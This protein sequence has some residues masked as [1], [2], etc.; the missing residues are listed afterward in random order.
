MALERAGQRVPALGAMAR[1]ER[2]PSTGGREGEGRWPCSGAGM[3][4]PQP[5]CGCSV[6]CRCPEQCPTPLVRSQRRDLC[7]GW[8][9]MPG[10]MPHSQVCPTSVPGA[11]PGTSCPMRPSCSAPCP[12]L[13][14][15]FSARFSAWCCALFPVQYRCPVQSQCLV[16]SPCNS[17]AVLGSRCNPSAFPV[18]S[19]CWAQFPV[20]SWFNPG[21]ISV[22]CPVPGS[23]QF[24]PG[25]ILV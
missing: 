25:V 12:G 11:V 13:C 2:G 3:A 9:P 22:L 15:G 18:P 17:G 23:V 4:G 1:G 24:N 21:A 16:Q 14:P 5:G 7:P 20:Q 8:C 6:R 10:A 19:R